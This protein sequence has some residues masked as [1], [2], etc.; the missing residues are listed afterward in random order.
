MDKGSALKSRVWITIILLVL[1]ISSIIIIWALPGFSGY[2]VV[3][4]IAF[5]SV[6]IAVAFADS[7]LKTMK[8]AAEATTHV[9]PMMPG[10]IQTPLEC[11]KCG[12]KLYREAGGPQNMF[13]CSKCGYYG[14]VGLEP[15]KAAGARRKKAGRV[16]KK[17]KR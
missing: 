5:I 15:E 17:R 16:R 10:Q 8:A 13:S 7:R 11:P 1:S 12:E 2:I 6:V 14:A 9:A 4:C 3:F